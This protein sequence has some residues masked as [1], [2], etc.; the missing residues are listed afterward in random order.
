MVRIF[1]IVDSTSFRVEAYWEKDRRKLN[2]AGDIIQT[3]FGFRSRFCGNKWVAGLKEELPNSLCRKVENSEKVTEGRTLKWLKMR[4]ADDSKML[5]V[6][7][8]QHPRGIPGLSAMKSF[9]RTIVKIPPRARKLRSI[10]P[11]LYVM[12]QWIQ[13]HSQWSLAAQCRR[14]WSQPK[15]GEF[16]QPENRALSNF[17][18]NKVR[19]S[20]GNFIFRTRLSRHLGG[21]FLTRSTKIWRASPGLIP[22]RSKRSSKR[23]PRHDPK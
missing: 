8:M 1:R 14:H 5:M 21:Y 4:G 19:E 9:C 7:S 10:F 2:F 11:I 23:N 12:P 13:M 6:I 20:G 22:K 16:H 17:Y 18:G 15:I 3:H